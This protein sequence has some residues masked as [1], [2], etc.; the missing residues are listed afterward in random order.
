MLSSTIIG[1]CKSG[2]KMWVA[3]GAYK[4]GDLFTL[5]RAKDDAFKFDT[6]AAGKKVILHGYAVARIID[7]CNDKDHKKGEDHAKKESG[8][9]A[10]PGT[11]TKEI[12]FFATKVI[13]LKN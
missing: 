3:D 13:Y 2:C 12:T 1:A 9:C 5:V 10:G 7:T 4:K 11:P 8:G 6:K